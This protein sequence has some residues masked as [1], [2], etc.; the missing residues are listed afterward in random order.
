M[1]C[2]NVVLYINWCDVVEPALIN[3]SVHN[4]LNKRN[5]RLPMKS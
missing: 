5:Q 4:F 3:Q 2:G 1:Y